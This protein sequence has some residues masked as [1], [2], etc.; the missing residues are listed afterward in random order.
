[1]FDDGR[2]IDETLQGQ[3][4]A[5][6]QLVRRYQDRLFNSMVRITGCPAEAEDVVQD[7]FVQAFVKLDRFKRESQFFTWLYRIALNTSISR[8]RKQKPTVSIDQ[9]QDA[10]GAVLAA[11]TE[12]VGS[13]LER[14]EQMAQL[15]AALNQLSEEYRKILVLRELEDEPY[16]SIAQIL[17]LPVGTVR[18]RLHR[19]RKQL[20]EVLKTRHEQFF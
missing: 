3:S 15:A 14:D 5:F 19:A 10:F 9:Q 2:L 16:E 1:V 7:A 12:E 20:H 4:E 8:H 18:S 13:A 6:G 11:N 17:E